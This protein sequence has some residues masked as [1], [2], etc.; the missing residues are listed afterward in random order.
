MRGGGSVFYWREASVELTGTARIGRGKEG[1]KEAD[2]SNQMS[3][4]A[5]KMTPTH[6]G[7]PPKFGSQV[8]VLQKKAKCR[9]KLKLQKKISTKTRSEIAREKEECGRKLF[10]YSPLSSFSSTFMREMH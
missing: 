3:A 5:A 8:L 6:S 1:K 2:P 10:I 4:L 7:D 9:T